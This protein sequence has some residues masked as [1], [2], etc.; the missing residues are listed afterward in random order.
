MRALANL[1]SELPIEHTIIECSEINAKLIA[2]LLLKVECDQV[3]LKLEYIKLGIGKNTK[4]KKKNLAA[5][6]LSWIRLYTYICEGKDLSIIE[7]LYVA[8][9]FLER[10]VNQS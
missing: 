6:P 5:L 2:G 3:K 7:N 9:E 4:K 8:A 1:N 10:A